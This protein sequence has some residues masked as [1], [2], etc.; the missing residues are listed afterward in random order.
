LPAN[1]SSQR[2]FD[3]LRLNCAR[4][5]ELEVLEKISGKS[6]LKIVLGEKGLVD[7]VS[8]IL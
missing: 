5:R 7:R 2:R 4:L 1:E 8:N 3:V 6:N